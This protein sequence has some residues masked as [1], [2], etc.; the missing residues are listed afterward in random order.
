[1]PV[2]AVFHLSGD[3][4]LCLKR[5]LFV[6]ISVLQ[7][8]MA[9]LVYRCPCLSSSQSWFSAVLD[10]LSGSKFHGTLVP[11]LQK[12]LKISPALYLQ[13][14]NGEANSVHERASEQYQWEK[15]FFFVSA[16]IFGPVIMINWYA[17]HLAKEQ[18]NRVTLHIPSCCCMGRAFA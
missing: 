17:V 8:E 9:G 11:T 4:W 7:S 18:M 12:V 1:M 14:F 3:V 15:L 5:K 6:W 2:G 16:W 13:V 10:Q